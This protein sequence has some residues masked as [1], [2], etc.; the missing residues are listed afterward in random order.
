MRLTL[1]EVQRATGGRIAGAPGSAD[2]V[3][4]GVTTD[5]RSLRKGGLFV[6]LRGPR[7]DGHDFIADAFRGGAAAVVASRIPGGITG[8]VVQVADALR[9][10][11]DLARHYR[12]TL[13][14]TVVGVTGSVGKTTTVKMCE[15]A[16]R[17]RLNVV[18]TRDEWN[19]EIGVPLT[20]LGLEP[21]HQVAVIEMAM[22]GLGQIA[23]LVDIASPQIGVVTTIGESHLELLGT[24]D[25][26]ARAK[27]ELID[28][29][30]DDGVGVLN[31]DDPRVYAL[32]ARSRARVVTYGMHPD[33][34]VHAVDVESMEQGIRFTI[35]AQAQRA[36]AAL[37]TW[38]THNVG[39]ALA[40]AAVAL[41][42]GLDVEAAAEGLAAYRPPKMRLQPV[43]LGDVLV[44]NDAY[45]ASPAS[46]EAAFDVLEALAH[47]RRT[48]A[49]LGEMKELG[50]ESPRLHREVGVSLARRRAALLVAVEQ[51][52]RQIAEGA[53]AGGMPPEAIIHLPSVDAASERVRGL[54]R[55]GDVV[56][57][58]GSRAL[59][60]ERIVDAIV[61]ART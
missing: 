12:R 25:N 46:M 50:P 39:N 1:A 18:R 14:V 58:K 32:A 20:L 54:I 10:L 53:A 2:T 13:S 34:D 59:G 56:L 42:C 61:E 44:I 36:D 52:G 55:P 15:A 40:A 17:T 5:T 27:G 11:A 16:L 6:A 28:G 30:P 7:A 24:I 60:M 38:G 48:V 57:V 8:P 51:G 9:A 43:P 41:A 22:R 49:V 4:T 21:A 31:R 33:A 37:R 45:N 29:L 3:V 26:V 23:E 19:A 47:G 35:V